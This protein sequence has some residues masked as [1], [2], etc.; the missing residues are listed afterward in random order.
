MAAIKPFRALRP[1]RELAPSVASPPYDVISTEEARQLARQNELSF[2]R[3]I[4]AEVD[5]PPS[6]DPHSEEVYR[7]GAENLRQLVEKGVLRRDPNPSIYIYR[8]EM[9]GRAQ[10][11]W[12]VGASTEEYRTGKIK[13]HE[14]TRPLKEEDRAR[15][16]EILSAQTGPVWLTYRS[17]KNLDQ[18]LEQLSSN[19]E[20]IFD[21]TD[22]AGVKHTGWKVDDPRE[23]EEIAELFREIPALYIADGH[24]RSAAAT[25]VAEKW[26]TEKGVSSDHPSQFFL[27]AV[28]PHHQLKI[29][30]YNRYI[31]D[32]GG[33][34]LSEFLNKLKE[35]FLVS[36]A[37]DLEGPAPPSPHTFDMYAGGRWFRLQLREEFVPSGGDPTAV[38]DVQILQTY[39]LEPLLGIKDP[40]RDERIEFIGGIRGYGELKRRVDEGGGVAF[41][42]YP[43]SLEQL[44]SIA[45]AGKIMP[46]KSTWFEPKL[47]S[48]LFVYP[49]EGE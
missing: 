8:L 13:K 27:A 22:S 26:R 34:T 4:R 31:K 35:K 33:Y 43:T 37:G 39:V 29:L 9:D 3:V 17:H 28:F 41:G 19:G 1:D 36:E 32:L 25:R 24:H 11:G 49:L 12:V 7:R 20:P 18:K 2:I 23:V 10:L 14:L 6:T 47:K 30:P 5:F 40:R 45:D 21:F 16:I 48:G 46:P 15:H 42:C 38:L 44:F